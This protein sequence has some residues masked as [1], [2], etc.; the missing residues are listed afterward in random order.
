MFERMNRRGAF[1]AV[2][3]GAIGGAC[4]APATASADAP[5]APDDTTK[6]KPCRPTVTCSA[7]LMAPGLSEL[8][9]GGN[10][11]H[12]NGTAQWS[13]PVLL[14]QGL[15]RWLELEIGTNGLTVF[16][17]TG[18]YTYFDDVVVGPKVLFLQQHGLLP[19]LSVSAEVSAPTFSAEGYERNWD[20]FFTAYASK[21]IGTF[22]VDVNAWLNLWRLGEGGAPQGLFST[23]ITKSLP[24]NFATEIGL[25]YQTGA[26]PNDPR[27][28]GVQGAVTY[29]PL[30]WLVFDAGADWGL[31]PS[32]RGYSIFGGV[33]FVPLVL[34]RPPRHE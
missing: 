4:L 24:A 13:L 31:F 18:G 33:A 9:F 28:A 19:A 34:W 14:K 11:S 26:D 23:A 22:R 12:G 3:T 32:E 21:D 25:F 20:L 15:L 2:L 10:L 30:S 1:A 5:A 6:V 8:E 29:S 17:D 7:D 27:D 16:R